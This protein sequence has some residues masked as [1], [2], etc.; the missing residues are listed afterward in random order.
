MAIGNPTC[1]DGLQ[2]DAYAAPYRM[3][4]QCIQYNRIRHRPY[5]F[6]TVTT[7]L[8]EPI[9]AAETSDPLESMGEKV[10]EYPSFETQ[11]RIAFVYCGV[12]SLT[13]KRS[14]ESIAA[15]CLMQRVAKRHLIVW[16]M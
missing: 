4:E 15:R 11:S 9:Q 12:I 1:Q 7:T 8:K 14:H 13:L 3:R 16:C 2:E 10:K 6:Y 5:A